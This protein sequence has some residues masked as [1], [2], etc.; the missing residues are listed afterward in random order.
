M[1]EHEIADIAAYHE[2]T[3]HRFSGYARG[4]S[5]IDWQAQ[6]D[7]FRRFAGAREI[8]LPFGADAHRVPFAAL[9]DGSTIAPAPASLQ[10]IALLLEISVALSAWKQY[11]SARWSL[12]CNPSSGNL[13]PTETYVVACKV[14]GLDDGVYHYRADLHALEQRCVLAG[15]PAAQGLFIGLSSVFWREAWKYGERAYRYCQ[16]DSGHALA[17]IGVAAATLGWTTSM[18]AGV[19]DAQLAQLLG[20]DRDA[21]FAEAE[22]E[23]PDL[24]LQLHPSAACTMDI[25]ALIAHCR[26]GNWSGVANVLDAR[27]RYAWPVIDRAAALCT[28]PARTGSGRQ[29]LANSVATPPLPAATAEPA[30]DL[31]RRRRSAQAFDGRTVMSQQDFFRLLDHVLAREPLAPWHALPWRPR[32]HL[33]LFVHRVA[34]L[35]PGLY[36]LPRHPGALELLQQSMRNDF[37]WFK[38]EAAP[39]HLPL[40]HLLTIH[41]ERAAATLSCQQAIA[42]DGCF[43]L[44]MLAE[45]EAH[46]HTAPWHYRELFWEAGAIGQLLY[47][48]AEACG[49]RGT[50]IG[51]Y[52][53]DEVH[54]VLGIKNRALQSVYHFTVGGAL[55]DARIAS[56]PPYDYAGR[57][58]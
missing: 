10:S 1:T 29:L 23:H 35:T 55:Q 17:A 5:D 33:V 54:E 20:I 32:V 27:H 26:N 56:L 46:L 47:L 36:A 7:A 3:K 14:E 19:G 13:H 30:A 2:R 15:S 31:F 24:L 37:D 22:R 25:D 45:F 53:D 11:G 41:C 57:G 9:F 38:V 8:P 50:G 48:D 28:K 12:R 49:L 16:H 44:A 4:P 52:F 6:P 21:D 18:Q 51:C 39:Q 40:Y 43:S 58:A 42:G 34:G